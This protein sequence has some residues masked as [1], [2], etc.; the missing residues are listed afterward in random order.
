MPNNLRYAHSRKMAKVRKLAL[1]GREKQ[2]LSLI[3][4]GFLYKQ[5]AC[6]L[7]ISIKTVEFHMAKILRKFKISD[8]YEL[9]ISALEAGSP[10]SN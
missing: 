8:R 5:V 10:S 7:E 3:R 9:E 1:T 2:V 4:Q 6:E